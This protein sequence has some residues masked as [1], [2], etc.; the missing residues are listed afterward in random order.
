MGILVF[1]VRVGMY[2]DLLNKEIVKM[3]KL[4]LDVFLFMGKLNKG[5]E[6]FIFNFMMIFM[7]L[8]FCEV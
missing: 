6:S 7:Y 5:W 2:D 8:K 3:I 4:S 1:D